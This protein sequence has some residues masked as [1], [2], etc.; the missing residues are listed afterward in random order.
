MM[1]TD[2]DVLVWSQPY[3]NLWIT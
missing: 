2:N 1:E 3:L